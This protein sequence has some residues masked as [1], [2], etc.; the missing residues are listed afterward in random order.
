MQTVWQDLRYGTRML[1]KSSGFTLIAVATL[2]LGIGANTAIFSVVHGVLLRALPYPDPERLVMV[3]T[4]R[5]TLQ[6]RLGLS[7]FPV[8]A[9]D[10]VDW[11]NQNQVF[12]QIAA[13]RA[14]ELNLTIS[15]EPEVLGAVRASANL[16]SLLGVSPVQGRTFVPE[17]DRPGAHRVVVISYGLWQRRWAGDPELIGRTI[18]LDNETYTVVGVMAPDF[19]FPR[20]GDLPPSF[21]FPGTVDLYLPIAFTPAEISNRTRSYLAVIARLN[22]GVSIKRANA[23]MEAL[24]GR[25]RQQHPQTNSDKGVWLV[26]LHQQVAGRVKTALLVL[27]GAVAFVL[28]ISCA[29]VAN[30]LLARGAARQ[31][32]MAIRAAIGASRGRVVRQLLTESLMLALSGGTLGLLLAWWGIDLLLAISPGNLPRADDIRLDNRV[33]GFTL[34]VSLLTGI[35]FGLL[36]ALQAARPDF[37]ETL[38]EGGRRAAGLPHNGFRSFL[39]VGEVALAFV[40]LIGGGLLLK[41]F[42]RLVGVDPG[43]DPRRV[44][45]MDVLLPRAKYRGAQTSAFFQQA[46]ERVRTL[47]GVEAAGAVYPLPLGGQQ[48]NTAFSIEGAPP[49]PGDSFF[50]CGQRWTSPDYFKT[51]RIPLVKGRLLVESDGTSAPRMVVINE[52]LARRYFAGQD[53]LGRRIAFD[54]S[55][56][57]PN[58]REIVGVVKDVKHSALDDEARPEFYLPLAQFPSSFMTLVVRTS[59]DPLQMTTAL[60]SQIRAVDKD[61]PVSNIQT[62]EQVLASS[63]APRRFNMLVLGMFALVGLA[64]AA[65]GLYGMMSYTVTERTHEIGIRMA[66]GAQPGEV[67]KLVIR[68]GIKLALVGLLMGLGGAL[69]L[70]RLMKALLFGVSATD[71]LT[72]A[73]IALWLTVVALLAC[74]IPARRAT[75]VDPMAALRCE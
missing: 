22:A 70:T 59:G 67:L 20:K 23:E 53:P 28:L 74:W 42:V 9:A 73:V 16:F 56:G 55:A 54:D 13:L 47:P 19:Q 43:F 40:L 71:Y 65:V 58:Y 4:H 60:R 10:F 51:L 36:P 8:A 33:V 49:L 72:F 11:S 39:I 48:N 3:W 24:A 62:M 44:L 25:L 41:S 30:L 5:P 57:K 35:A 14:Q 17:E 52:A 69:A 37:N 12:D 26:A 21:E 75:R 38:K 27:L 64:L 6:A 63:V 15:G 45:T 1:L 32:E 46:L 7:E 31:K 66:L 29:N 61:Q 34:L 2:A 50:A 68:Q 18:T